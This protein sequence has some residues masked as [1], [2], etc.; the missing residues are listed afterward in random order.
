MEKYRWQKIVDTTF[1]FQKRSME[2]ETKA[3]SEFQNRRKANA[4]TRVERNTQIQ[5]IWAVRITARGSSRKANHLVKVVWETN[6]ITEFSRSL[7]SPEKINQS[8]WRTLKFQKKKKKKKKI[9]RWVDWQKFIYVAW[10]NIKNCAQRTAWLLIEE[11]EV[12][13]R[14]K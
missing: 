1:K 14:M 3:W 9:S 8:L 7:V 2:T 5:K 10:N 11:S 13:H 12:R 4:D 6:I